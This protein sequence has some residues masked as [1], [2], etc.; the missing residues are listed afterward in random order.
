MS[1]DHAMSKVMTRTAC[2][3]P[4]VASFVFVVMLLLTALHPWRI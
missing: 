4:T 1:P 2:A 3:L